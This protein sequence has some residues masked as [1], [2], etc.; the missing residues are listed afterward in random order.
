MYIHTKQEFAVHLGRKSGYI[1]EDSRTFGYTFIPIRKTVTDCLLE[2][3]TFGVFPRCVHLH[4][5]HIYPT[6]FEHIVQTSTITKLDA[7]KAINNFDER[8]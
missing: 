3:K 5:Y 2:N 1:V 7:K 6:V 8:F 4:I